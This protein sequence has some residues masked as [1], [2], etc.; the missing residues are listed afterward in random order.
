[1]PFKTGH[2]KE[3][4]IYWWGSGGGAIRMKVISA[5]KSRVKREKIKLSAS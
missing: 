5:K 2:F 3:N 4:L 1:L